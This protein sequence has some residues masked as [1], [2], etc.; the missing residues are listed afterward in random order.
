[1][2]VWRA[3]TVIILASTGSTLIFVTKDDVTKPA[4][5]PKQ[6]AIRKAITGFSPHTSIAP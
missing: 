4:A 1:M 2:K 6:A 3:V 5:V